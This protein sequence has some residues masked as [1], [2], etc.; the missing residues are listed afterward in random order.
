MVLKN[1]VVILLLLAFNSITHAQSIGIKTN[2]AHW[3]AGGTPNLGIETA[4]TS[5]YTLNVEGGYNWFAFSEE[6]RAKH[7]I[8]QSE[9][10][11]WLC[12]SFNGH[13]FG[14]HALAGE[15]N[16]G[17]IDIPIGRLKD[18]KGN[19]YEGFGVGAGL[20]YGY[21]WPISKALNFELSLGAGYVYLDY[22]KYRCAK[23][24]EKIKDDTNHY[25]GITRASVSLIYIIK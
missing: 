12:E 16:I 5:K 21:Q 10:R 6:K 7:W 4:L 19:R 17:K 23:C 20:S 18:W 25:F 1:F 13:F 15:Y 8:V 3:L 14:L 22:E 24:G 9:L 11:Y 2:L